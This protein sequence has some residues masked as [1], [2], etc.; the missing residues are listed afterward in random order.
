MPAL[1][2]MRCART[3]NLDSRAAC[4]KPMIRMREQIR[5]FMIELVGVITPMKQ[6]QWDLASN[7][8]IYPVNV[9]LLVTSLAA[10]D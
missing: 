8:G 5:D 6:M 3:H 1:P 4:D 7:L 10:V 2:D 9:T